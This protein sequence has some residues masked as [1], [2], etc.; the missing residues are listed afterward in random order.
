MLKLI[1][2]VI[3]LLVIV[4]ICF[5][6]DS[7]RA[8]FSVQIRNL[9]NPYQV[10][11]VFV[12]PEETIDFKVEADSI[13]GSFTLMSTKGEAR[14]L[15][16][17]AWQWTAP[18]ETGHYIITVFNPAFNDSVIFNVFVIIPYEHLDGEFLNGY[19]IGTYPSKP[20][21]GL[22]IYKTPRGFIELTADNH[23]THVSPHFTLKQFR[24]KQTKSF[25]EY[26]ILRSRLLLKLELILEQVNAKGYR[27]ETFNVLSGYRTPYYNAL[28]GNVKYSRHCW[29]GAADI[30]IDEN[31]KDNMMD[32]LNNDG[33]SDYHDAQIL[34]DIIDELYGKA[35][36][37]PYVGGLGKY[38][39]TS[40]HGPFVHIDVR[41]FHARW[42]D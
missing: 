16:K 25:P 6:Y 11:G 33:A 14:S 31:P 23:N 28:I 15:Q 38:K 8:S 5:A 1:R 24:S 17:N 12:L 18:K 3:C 2:A 26:I 13:S 10:L 19:R 30:F 7:G 27:A 9:V 36:Y 37:T 29:G 41:G 42:G 4:G 20:L 34:Y 40:A 21:K 22:E 32:D 39:K 35:F